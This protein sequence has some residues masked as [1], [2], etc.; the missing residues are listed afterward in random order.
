MV[1]LYLSGVK[2]TAPWVSL[3]S[4]TMFCSVVLFWVHPGPRPKL[5][6]L[7]LILVLI[8]ALGARLLALRLRH[9][10]LQVGERLI[11]GGYR[12]GAGRDAVQ[13]E[14]LER[15]ERATVERSGQGGA[16]GVVDLSVAEVEQLELLQPSRRRRRRTCRRRRHEGGEALVA[17]RVA[18]E[19]KLLQRGPPP[20]GR[21]EGHQPRVA[22]SGVVQFEGLEPRQGASAQGGGERRG[23]CVAHMHT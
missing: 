3:S 22:D 17:E 23:A 15:R 12:C 1:E 20:Q 18:L 5:L 8:L 14:R 10:G 21:R 4:K 9:P 7:I 2:V 6:V 13:G 16:T 19:F 11:H